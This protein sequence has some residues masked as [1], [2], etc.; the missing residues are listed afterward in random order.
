MSAGSRAFLADLIDYAGL[1]PPAD[2]DLAP[3]V[4]N[5]AAYR[6]GADAW[7]LGRFIVPAGR[8]GD[9]DAHADAFSAAPP[10]RF[11]VLGHAPDAGGAEAWAAAARRT[12][13]D[14]RAFE[15]RH[16]GRAVCDRRPAAAPPPH[17]AA[18]D[19]EPHRPLVPHQAGGVG[20][21]HDPR[22]C[23]RGLPVRFRPGEAGRRRRLA[24]M[25]AG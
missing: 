18:P 21:R 2:L 25:L 22:R 3:A 12:L 7:M 17:P 24:G 1:F 23:P 6:G 5:F 8:L 15:R 14:A 4:R 16:D 11:S 20:N 9:L 10:A 19:R 13:A